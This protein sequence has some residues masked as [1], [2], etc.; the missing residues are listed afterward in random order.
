[1]GTPSELL[2]F[3]QS[4][5]WK[6]VRAYVRRRDHGICQQCG[7]IGQEVHHKVAL[8]LQNYQSEIAIDPDNLVLLCKSCHD[9]E[10]GAD[11]IRPDVMF[12]EYGRLKP[13]KT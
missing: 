4:K 6:Q 9:A 12:D 8:N 2:K 3:Y 11:K 7:G 10:R 5:K 13:R 1:M